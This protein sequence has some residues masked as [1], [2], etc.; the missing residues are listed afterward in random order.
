M[1]E[2]DCL[3]AN[4]MHLVSVVLDPALVVIAPRHSGGVHH[5]FEAGGDIRFRCELAGMRGKGLIQY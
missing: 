2:Y 3:Q 4:F 1:V 5:K